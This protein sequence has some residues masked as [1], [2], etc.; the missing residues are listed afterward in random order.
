M[1]KIFLIRH[2]VTEH[3]KQYR[4]CGISDV[5]LSEL[6]CRQAELV[7]QI[8][9]EKPIPPIYASPLKRCLEIGIAA[10]KGGRI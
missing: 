8:L 4:Y 3:N 9:I 7:G 1:Q 10:Q 5:L 6:G 2:A